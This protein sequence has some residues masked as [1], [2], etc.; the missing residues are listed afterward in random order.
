MLVP[1]EEPSPRVWENIE[2]SLE[3]EGFIRPVRGTVRMEPFLIPSPRRSN[4]YGWAGAAALALV[5]LTT[6]AYYRL[7]SPAVVNTPTAT[8]SA[9]LGTIDTNGMSEDDKPI[10]QAISNKNPSV[11]AAYSKRMRSVETYINEAK[12]SVELN[13]GDDIARQQLMNAYQQRDTLHEMAVSYTNR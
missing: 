6:L 5:S 9:F 8:N 12:H 1:M 2:R 10:V 3:R 11:G 7:Q 4:F 13:P